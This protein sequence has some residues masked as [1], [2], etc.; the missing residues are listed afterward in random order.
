[1]L[2]MSQA[3]QYIRTTA[4]A[5][6]ER[7]NVGGRTAVRADRVDAELDAVGASINALQENLEAIQR[8]DQQLRDG[9]VT[10]QSIRADTAMMFGGRAFT[11]RG[12][13]VTAT[14]YAVNDFVEI[15]NATYV[16]LVAH[17]S[18]VFAT[19]RAAG[20]WQI[21]PGQPN[22]ADTIFTPTSEVVATD[23]QAAIEL[24]MAASRRANLP[25]FAF[26]YG[27]F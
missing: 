5:E 2:G 8:D 20:K 9:I 13:W 18:G 14:A 23:V 4:F 6:D 27:A 25:D 19:D 11:P 17:S 21:F 15:S 1:M 3:P 7:L 26:N 10:P 24:V 16:C 22:A 12:L